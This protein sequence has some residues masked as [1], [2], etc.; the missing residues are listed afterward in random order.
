MPYLKQL[1]R[2][3]QAAQIYMRYKDVTVRQTT[4]NYHKF[5][6]Q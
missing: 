4:I 6:K 2:I 5:T 1:D 3:L